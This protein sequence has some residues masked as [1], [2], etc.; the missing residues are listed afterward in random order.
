M[1]RGSTEHL[2]AALAS[3]AAPVKPLAPP[4]KRALATLAGIA[5]VGGIGVYFIADLSQLLRRYSGREHMMVLEML[6]MLMTGALAV[7]GAFFVSVPGR[8]RMWLLFPLPSFLAWIGLSGMGCY[9]EVIRSGPAGWEIGHSVQCLIFIVAFSVLLGVPLA[10][11]LSRARPLHSLP[12]AILGG[13]GVAALS[14]FLLQFFHR[15]ASTFVDLGVHLV[16]IAL[17]VLTTGLFNRRALSPA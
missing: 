8:S 6:A 13:L 11:R 14:A 1:T 2:I 3:D 7:T 12:V 15:S 4:L 5:L 10:W 16:A 17:V 9:A